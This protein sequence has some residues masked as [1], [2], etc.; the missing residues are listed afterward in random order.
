M[1][2]LITKITAT[3]D[4]PAERANRLKRFIEIAVAYE[5]GHPVNTIE[6][7]HGCTRSTILRYARI[8]GLPKRPRHFDVKTRR[9]VIRLYRAKLPVA[10]IAKRCMVSTAYVSKTATEEGIKRK[11]QG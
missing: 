7:R 2:D 11:P 5:A 4:F 6:Q 1:R 8:A 3:L 9:R 10:V